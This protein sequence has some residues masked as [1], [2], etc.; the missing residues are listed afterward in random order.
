M[1]GQNFSG[2]NSWA[3]VCAAR[4]CAPA[5]HVRQLFRWGQDGR[6]GETYSRGGYTDA[7]TD[8]D[9]VGVG[10]LRID[11]QDVLY[12][13]IK[14]VGNGAQGIPGLNRVDEA[15]DLGIRGLAVI[16]LCRL[17]LNG[18]AITN[19]LSPGCTR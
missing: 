1:G 12:R 19:M 18:R 13:D 5:F 10:N 2:K 11:C 15:I 7:L 16:R 4:R 14:T 6:A 3:T 8:Q 17:T 9:L